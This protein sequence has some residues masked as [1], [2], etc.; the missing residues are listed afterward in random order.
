MI[1]SIILLLKRDLLVARYHKIRIRSHLDF[2]RMESLGYDWQMYCAI[3][4]GKI[5]QIDT[6]K[7]LKFELA[8]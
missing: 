7:N 8:R 3:K 6:G 4:A 5:G 1:P 2:L